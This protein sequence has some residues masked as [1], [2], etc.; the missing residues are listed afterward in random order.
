ML[1]DIRVTKDLVERI[2]RLRVLYREAVSLARDVRDRVMRVVREKIER[3]IEPVYVEDEFI[4]V[5]AARESE[6]EILRIPVLIDDREA[7][8]VVLEDGG[9]RVEY[10]W[11]DRVDTGSEF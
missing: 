2:M 8:I 11:S 9:I 5:W 3:N 6:K 10:L 4:I 7:Y 1:S